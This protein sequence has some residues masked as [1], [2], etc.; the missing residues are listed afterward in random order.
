MNAIQ[1]AADD[2]VASFACQ[3]GFADG[4]K[5]PRAVAARRGWLAGFDAGVQALLLE[6]AA[7]RLRQEAAET[8]RESDE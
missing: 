2:Y 3:W 6:Q 1:K 4:A 5:D 7:P 8:P